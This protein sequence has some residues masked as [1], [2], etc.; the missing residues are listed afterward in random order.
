MSTQ[1]RTVS[2]PAEGFGAPKDRQGHATGVAGLPAGT[3]VF[4][5]D[6]HISLADDIFYERFPE[7]LKDQAPRVVYE[8]GAW[9]LAVGGRTFLP[10]EFTAVLMQYDP[11]AG[12][13]TG[14]IDA[15]CASSSPTASIGSWPSRT[16]CSASCGCRTKTSGSAASASTTST[17]PRSRSSRVGGSSASG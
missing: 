13:S 11:L 10:R 14:D 8:D 3:E 12:S 7:E 1:V 9:N 17:S 5:A 4:S 15:R 16:R 6:D 2:Y